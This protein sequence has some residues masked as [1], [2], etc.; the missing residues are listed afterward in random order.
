MERTQ[1]QAASKDPLPVGL[2]RSRKVTLSKQG[3]RAGVPTDEEG[4][5]LKANNKGVVTSVRLNRVSPD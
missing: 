3:A 4:R 2:R 5:P 1:V